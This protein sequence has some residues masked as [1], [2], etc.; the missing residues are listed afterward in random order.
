MKLQQGNIVNLFIFSIFEY[1][2][3][4]TT[5]RVNYWLLDTWLSWWQY[6]YSY[7]VDY[8]SRAHIYLEKDWMYWSKPKYLPGNS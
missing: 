2:F 7:L 6:L 4:G 5:K 8:R 1:L 3:L